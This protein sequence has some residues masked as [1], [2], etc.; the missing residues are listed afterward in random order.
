MVGLLWR[1]VDNSNKISMPWKELRNGP[2][3]VEKTLLLDY[4]SPILPK[5]F[6]L[7][8]KNKHWAVV[9]S[10]VG[11]QLILATVRQTPSHE[12]TNTIANE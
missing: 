8:I 1:Q 6:W 11:H 12:N 2:M 3:S 10:I 9:M 5:S 7:A 4:V